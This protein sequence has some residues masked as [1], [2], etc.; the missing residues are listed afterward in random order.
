MTL[1]SI[2]ADYTV[3]KHQDREPKDDNKN[4]NQFRQEFALH[5]L[6]FY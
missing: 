1:P 3:S 2:P 4:I 6:Q 5:S